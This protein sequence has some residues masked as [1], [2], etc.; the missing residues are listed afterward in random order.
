MCHERKSLHH[1]SS[2]T[3]I[4]LY[5]EQHNR[6]KKKTLNQSGLHTLKHSIAVPAWCWNAIFAMIKEVF[7]IEPFLLNFNFKMH[8]NFLLTIEN[9]LQKD[10]IVEKQYLLILLNQ[11]IYIKCATKW[12][13][14]TR[15]TSENHLTAQTEPNIYDFILTL[16]I[17]KARCLR[18]SSK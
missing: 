14:T 15:R 2:S 10:L 9:F 5:P 1:H 11:N 18:R 17:W 3:I 12:S 16:W 13:H 4:L 7:L 8:Q 6:R